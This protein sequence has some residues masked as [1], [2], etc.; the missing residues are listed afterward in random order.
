MFGE[1][2][3]YYYDTH[4]DKIF[5]PE[6]DDPD[7]PKFMGPQVSYNCVY[8]D[9]H[10]LE[11]FGTDIGIRVWDEQKKKAHTITTETGL[12]NNSISSII[13]DDSGIYWVSTVSGISRIELKRLLEDMISHSQ[14]Q[15]RR[16]I[17]GRKVL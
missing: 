13:E 8:K 2:G 15:F 16:R 9:S 5:V 14:L 4:K 7:N 12:A 6:I 17:A 1:N 11:W 3:I 10:S